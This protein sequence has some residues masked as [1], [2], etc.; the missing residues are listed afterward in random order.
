[1]SDYRFSFAIA[2]EGTATAPGKTR[3]QARRWLQEVLT[4]GMSPD[5]LAHQPDI[6][7]TDVVEDTPD[8]TAIE[9]V[10]TP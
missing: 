6:T 8:I 1:M 10:T 3:A 7:I 9:E 2:V 4:A 5:L